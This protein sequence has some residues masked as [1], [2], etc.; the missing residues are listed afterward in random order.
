MMAFPGPIVSVLIPVYNSETYLEQCLVSV[1]NQS[2]KD[3]E[4]IIINDGS[5]DGSPAIIQRYQDSDNRVRVITKSNSGYGDSLNIGIDS[6]EGEYISIVESDDLIPSDFLEKLY[7]EATSFT[8]HIDV[9]KSDYEVFTTDE[10]RKNSLRKALD[11]EN[12]Y[13]RPIVEDNSDLLLKMDVHNWNG[14]YRRDYLNQNKI[15][16]NTTPGASYQDTGFRFQYLTRGG[17]ILF[18]HGPRYQYRVDNPTSSIRTNDNKVFAIVDEYN[19]IE[20]YLKDNG[21][22][23]KFGEGFS[24]NRYLSYKW[25]FNSIS[26]QNKKIFVVRWREELSKNDYGNEQRGF[27]QNIDEWMVRNLPI[28]L[29]IAIAGTA[30][31]VL[32]KLGII[33]DV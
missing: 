11:D 17:S 8:P 24:T 21:L 33:S 10:K 32:L 23:E 30:H 15:R 18:I 20:G 4:I 13:G 29:Y 25:N 12:S 3:I 19:F 27:K 31:D 1:T 28:S 7:S 26:K 16:H 9:V 2:L 14:I 5:T 22:I 6:A